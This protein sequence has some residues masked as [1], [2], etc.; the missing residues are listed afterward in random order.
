MFFRVKKAGKKCFSLIELLIVIGIMGAL[1][2]LI[3]PSFSDSETA[4]KDAACDYNQAGTLR[5]LT[6]FHSANG[7]YPSGF[8]TGLKDGG[9]EIMENL[10]TAATYNFGTASAPETLSGGEAASLEKAGIVSLAYDSNGLPKA[11]VNSEGAVAA[12]V[13]VPVVKTTGAYWTE[14]INV[15]TGKVDPAGEKVKVRGIPLT[16]VA[17]LGAKSDYTNGD[18]TATVAKNFRKETEPDFKI[19]PLFVAP[20]VDWDTFYKDGPKPSKISIAMTGKCPWG[21]ADQARYYIA[22]FKV[23]SDGTAAKL[24]ATSC[25]DCGILDGAMF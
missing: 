22:F 17:A 3:L 21:K 12:D 23:Y 16:D 9:S 2:A 5:Y 24:L 8:H 25:P 6:M 14:T 18:L 4:A 11:I 1:A 7:V 10:T 15:A 13:K 20:T 19:V